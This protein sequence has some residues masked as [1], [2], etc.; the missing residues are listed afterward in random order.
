MGREP[1]RCDAVEPARRCRRDPYEIQVITPMFGGGVSAGECD[2]LT[3]IRPSS[4]R[5]H[6]RF[7][8]RA[9][10]GAPLSLQELRE[11]EGSIWGTTD[12]P[13]RVGIRVQPINKGTRERCAEYPPG[14][15]FPK[16]LPD[17]AAYAIFPFQGGKD[18]NPPPREAKKNLRFK[19]FLEYDEEYSRDVGAALWAWLNFGGIGSRTR[20]GCGALYCKTFAPETTSPPEVRGWVKKKFAEYSIRLPQNP[21]QWPAL[22]QYPVTGR[23]LENPLEAWKRAV[24]LLRTYRQGDGVGRN[25]G[26]RTRP[27]RSRWPEPDSLRSLTGVGE[28]RH[29]GSITVHKPAFPRAE[30]GLPIIFHFTAND[31]GDAANNCELYPTGKN[32]MA[33]PLILRPL[34]FGNGTQAVAMTLRLGVEP[35]HELELRKIAVNPTLQDAQIRRPD[36]G[37]YSNSPLRGSPTGS[38]LDGFMRF[39]SEKL[40]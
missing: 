5:G 33:S 2:D 32:R 3:P 28:A 4:I 29:K 9:T 10:R 38:A 18:A 26:T 17:Y 24:D 35:L 37:T 8:W 20:R 34:A 25:P 36:L 7:W 13:S 6:L 11:T 1:S 16:P 31:P 27:G 23:A 22:W 15:R 39:A 30:F 12:Q 19:L 40:R 21:P 14:S